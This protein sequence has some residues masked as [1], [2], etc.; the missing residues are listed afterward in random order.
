[1]SERVWHRVQESCD[2]PSCADVKGLAREL[3]AERAE[4]ERL[5]EACMRTNAAVCQSLGKALG[6]PWFKDD[7]K[8][9]PGATEADG[10]CVGEHVA[11]SVAEEAARALK[12]WEELHGAIR[13]HDVP[14]DD[15]ECYYCDF[16]GTEVTAQD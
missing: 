16:C 8:N 11:E 7:Q 4:V 3:A 12:R 13:A 14:D 1:M 5:R 10:V 9:F 2:C 6:Y 15:D